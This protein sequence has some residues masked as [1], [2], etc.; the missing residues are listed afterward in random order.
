[1]Q[2]YLSNLTL[3]AKFSAS[4]FELIKLCCHFNHGFS[5]FAVCE[6]LFYLCL[7]IPIS[8]PFK[9]GTFKNEQIS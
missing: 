1:M 9:N 7:L 8:I 6:D 2:Y 5:K 3:S 4:G